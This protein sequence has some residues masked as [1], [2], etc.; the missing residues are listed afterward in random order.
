MSKSTSV[1]GDEHLH[2]LQLL[3]QD[4]E[5]NQHKLF[6]IRDELSFVSSKKINLISHSMVCN[7]H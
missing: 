1:E 3:K 6:A 5:E 4:V 2:E 7:M